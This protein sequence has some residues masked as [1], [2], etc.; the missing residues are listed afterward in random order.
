MMIRWWPAAVFVH[1][2]I[3]QFRAYATVG[4]AVLP[5]LTVRTVLT[6]VSSPVS[7][8]QEFRYIY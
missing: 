8:Y 3:V 7:Y 4:S 6:N 2:G 1:F 5:E